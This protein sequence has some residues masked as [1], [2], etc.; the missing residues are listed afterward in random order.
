[1][2]FRYVEKSTKIAVIAIIA[3]VIIIIAGC[4]ITFHT[5]FH[6]NPEKTDFEIS[7]VRENFLERSEIK[8]DGN[9]FSYHGAQTHSQSTGSGVSK[10]KKLTDEEIREI[11][12][13]VVKKKMVFLDSRKF[14]K[15][16]KLVLQLKEFTRIIGENMGI[17]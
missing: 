15:P 1:M 6:F 10:F 8:L 3:A 14:I 13:Y 9:E 7:L 5:V 11:F 12:K 16:T 17:L 4:F 2:V